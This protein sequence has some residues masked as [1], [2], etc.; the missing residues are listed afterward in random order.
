MRK[1]LSCC[2]IRARCFIRCIKSSALQFVLNDGL[3]R[4]AAVALQPMLPRRFFVALRTMRE[5]WMRSNLHFEK[6][7]TLSPELKAQLK[8]E[9]A[10]E[11]LRLSQ[12]L[13]RDLTHW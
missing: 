12:L 7:P 10:P 6:R 13:R 5:K 1:S 3:V 8:R 9:F 4:R 2:G 11:I